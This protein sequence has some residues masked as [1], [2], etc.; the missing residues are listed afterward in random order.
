MVVSSRSARIVTS[1]FSRELPGPGLLA[2]GSGCNNI[3]TV[4]TYMGYE[5]LI[6]LLAIVVVFGIPVAYS[7]FRKPP[8]SDPAD[9]PKESPESRH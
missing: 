2:D 5:I 8:P 9:P 7:L 3:I 4:D 6:V 1:R